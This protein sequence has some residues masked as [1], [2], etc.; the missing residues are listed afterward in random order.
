MDV[1]R[2]I[3]AAAVMIAAVTILVKIV[4]LA[5]ELVVASRLGRGDVLDAFII[6]NALPSYAVNVIAGSFSAAIVPTFIEVLHG[7][8]RNE[9]QR[10]LASVSLLSVLL[11][12]AATV[13]LA[14]AIPLV[15][16]YMASGFPEAKLALTRQMFYMLLPSL[17]LSGMA[18]ICGAVLNAHE[19]FVVAALSPA[20]VAIVTIVMLLALPHERAA[21]ALAGGVVMG[22]GA[23]VCLLA[24]TL[25]RQGYHVTPWWHGQTDVLR[26]TI[27]Q[28]VPMI[29]GATL[30]GSTT[31]VNQAMAAMLDPGS[32]A[33]LEYANKLVM[34]VIEL[35]ATALGTAALPYFSKQ[36]ARRDWE[37]LRR[38]RNFYVTSVFCIALPLVGLIA[39]Y[40]DDIVQLVF[41]RGA[42]ESD[43][44]ILVGRV[45]QCFI[46]QVPFYIAGILIVRIISAIKENHILFYGNIISIVLNVTLNYILMQW[47]GVAGIALSTSIVLVIS[48]FYLS[49]ALNRKLRVSPHNDGYMPAAVESHGDSN[50]NV[51][52]PP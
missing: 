43:D 21:Q 46:I 44:T 3:F 13:L 49:F 32:V 19:H 16:P 29:A 2:K 18:S 47:L 22:M 6:A 50:K 33:A 35:G 41:E 4:G 28:Y 15:L 42:F 31:V 23:Q 52:T 27:R 51:Q 8:S 5:R 45:L 48:F 7:R 11:L 14:L 12:V 34:L 1:T 38:T 25:W 39:V 17:V 40:A 10:L 20:L 24:W 30:I 9:A 26:Q 36:V 37:E